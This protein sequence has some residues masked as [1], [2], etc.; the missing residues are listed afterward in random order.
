M[1][2]HLIESLS[3]QHDKHDKEVY[4]RDGVKSIKRCCM[5]YE[6]Q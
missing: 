6:R 5:W 3:T 4:A 1:I 2:C